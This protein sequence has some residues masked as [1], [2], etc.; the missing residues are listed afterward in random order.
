MAI[1]GDLE[2]IDAHGVYLIK[3][4]FISDF[5][6]IISNLEMFLRLSIK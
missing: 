2:L 6:F 1:I 3:Y 5:S 4:G